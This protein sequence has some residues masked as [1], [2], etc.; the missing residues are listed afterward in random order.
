MS[1]KKFALAS[2]VNS[3]LLCKDGTGNYVVST[4]Y[5]GNQRYSDLVKTFYS[6]DEAFEFIKEKE[7]Y[8][9]EP[10]IF[11]EETETAGN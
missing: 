6:K 2:T 1:T 10:V 3:G 11:N 5:T 7:F 8:A 9:L 4:E